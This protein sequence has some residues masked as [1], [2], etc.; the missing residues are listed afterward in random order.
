M[1]YVQAALAI[2]GAAYGVI[3]G[4][5]TNKAQKKGLGLQAAAQRTATDAA[6]RQQRQADEAAAR[7]NAKKPDVSALLAGEQGFGV[8]SMLTG[9]AG[10]ALNRLRLGR[11]SALGG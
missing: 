2:A 1:G 4:E 11:S 3:Q 6:M 9:P 7:A 5:R 10:V 8:S